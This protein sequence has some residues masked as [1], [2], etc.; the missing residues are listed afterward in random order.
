[1]K[2]IR[3]IFTLSLTI[4][5]IV[6]LSNRIGKV[7]PLGSFLDPFNGIWQNAETDSV[8]MPKE[9][10]L[11][12]LKGKVTVVYDEQ[13]IPHI[14]AENDDDLY[15]A[16]GYVTAY[17]RLWQMEF[18]THAA[19]GRLSEIIGEESKV[20]DF[21]RSQRRKGM[22]FGAKKALQMIE[23]NDT[24]RRM[25]DAYS[26]GVNAYINSLTYKELPFEYKL[27]DYRPEAWNP[28]KTAL[29]LKHMAN[30]LS[31]GES[32]IELTNALRLFG[33]QYFDMLYPDYLP[34]QDPIVNQ[35]NQW[36]FTPVALDS[37]AALSFPDSLYMQKTLEKTA[38][39]TGSNNW[40]VNSSKTASGNAILCN[41]PHLELSLPSIWFAIQLKS[42][43]INVMGASLPG[44]TGVIVGFNDSISW[45]VTNAQRDLV[46]WYRITYKDASRNEYMLDGKW[47]KTEKKIE[48][49]K[50]RGK[51]SYYD[52]VCYTIWGP[53]SFDNQFRSPKND[54]NGLAMRWIAH[55]ESDEAFAFYKL[56]RAK[57]YP[58]YLNA[59]RYFSCPAQN[60]AYAGVNGE[61]A[62]WIQGKFPAKWKEQGKFVMDGSLSSQ[63]W[64]TYIPQEHLVHQYNPKRGFVSS[65][66]QHPVDSTYPYYVTAH[67][68]EYYRN[69]RINRVLDSLQK[70]SVSDLMKLQNDNYNLQAAE[71]LPFFLSQLD[72]SSLNRPQK[73]AFMLLSK[74]K[75]INDPDLAAPA[76]Y[77]IW[78]E[79]I[80]KQLLWDEMK[81][82]SYSLQLP[83]AFN[84]IRLLK[85]NP[86][87]SYSDIQKTPERETVRGLLRLSFKMTIDSA[88]SWKQNNKEPLQ[89]ALYRN[90]T[91]RHLAMLPSL[92]SSRLINGGYGSTVNATG[93]RN[94]P[95]WRMVAEMDKKG[96]KAWGVYPGGQS[97]NP[98]SPYYQNMIDQWSAGKYFQLQFLKSPNDKNEKIMLVQQ[99]TGK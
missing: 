6:A 44:A 67:S 84:T 22:I 92:G 56:N 23:K 31:T 65:A 70:I 46:D 93:M 88:D 60:I 83:S 19:A 53:V 32:D 98:G 35:P 17:H 68:F 58:E 99:L 52:T 27:L 4:G 3:L 62:L 5:V 89:W 25:V 48:E 2:I 1:M 66:N 71:S 79:I 34:E 21:D 80:Y 50:I 90:T 86:D 37:T 78:W 45:G 15:F 54:K 38:E 94:A 95:S 73:E 61:V 75:Y 91:V 28:L 9:L 64:Q 55:D 24:T 96:V 13:L 51:V 47:L 36:K 42:P 33:K 81:D 82:K 72:S 49:I 8:A 29:L 69:R 57:N 97:G 43:T 20:L 30:T 39:G 26:K 18:Q 77:Q 87:L 41:D 10:K 74:W 7:P 63:K 12:G 85:N 14:F 76:Y 59:I 11:E 16:Q 40:A